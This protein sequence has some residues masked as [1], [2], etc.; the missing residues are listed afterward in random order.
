[1]SFRE[2][3]PIIRDEPPLSTMYIL[4]VSFRIEEL[5]V[6]CVLNDLQIILAP[7]C[8]VYLLDRRVVH[9]DIFRFCCRSGS[10]SEMEISLN[11]ALSKR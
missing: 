9:L 5:L 6:K 8:T 2:E 10:R 11:V 4:V 3:N 1:M 7:R